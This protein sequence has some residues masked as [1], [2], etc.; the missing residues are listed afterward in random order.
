MIYFLYNHS[1]SIYIS[2][3]S[4]IFLIWNNGEKHQQFIEKDFKNGFFIDEVSCSEDDNS[5]YFDNH[6]MAT[7]CIWK[8][9]IYAQEL[10]KIVLDHEAEEA[11]AFT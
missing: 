6:G 8:Y 11:F 7:A 4:D 5:I 10:S 1:Q 2:M 9:G 3:S